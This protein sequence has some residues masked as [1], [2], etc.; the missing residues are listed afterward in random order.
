MPEQPVYVYVA[1]RHVP[2]QVGVLLEYREVPLGRAYGYVAV[3]PLLVSLLYLPQH[4]LAV[5]VGERM[6]R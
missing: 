5:V 4:A 6:A 2:V 1:R 3:G